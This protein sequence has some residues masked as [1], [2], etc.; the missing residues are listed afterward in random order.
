MQSSLPE[1]GLKLWVQ[2]QCLTFSVSAALWARG[3]LP[4]VARCCRPGDKPAAPAGSCMPPHCKLSQLSSGSRRPAS[5][6]R[7]VGLDC[8]ALKRRTDPEADEPS[9]E[10]DTV[11]AGP[12]LTASLT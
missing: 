10:Q 6:Q 4:T 1:G 5:L 2:N 8:A 11:P 12:L 9:A 7:P 3:A